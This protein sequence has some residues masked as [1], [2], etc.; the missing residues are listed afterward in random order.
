MNALDNV[1][2]LIGWLSGTVIPLVETAGGDTTSLEA[3]LK[4]LED[5]EYGIRCA[6]GQVDPDA[7]LEEQAEWDLAANEGW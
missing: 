6:M 5:E 1:L 7:G 4:D 2:N 3:E